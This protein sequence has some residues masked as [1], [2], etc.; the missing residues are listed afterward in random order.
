MK[1]VF[2]VY[3]SD[4]SNSDWLVGRSVGRTVGWLVGMGWW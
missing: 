2:V 4:M 3:E 1:R